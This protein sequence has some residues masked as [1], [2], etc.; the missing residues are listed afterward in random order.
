VNQGRSQTDNATNGRKGLVQYY[1]Q[2]ANHYDE[3]RFA[4]S[5]GRYL[6]AQERR[7]L[8]RWLSPFQGGTILDLACGTGRLLDLATHGIDA[9]ESMIHLARHKHPH[10]QLRCIEAG[11]ITELPTSFDAIF[12]LHFFMH[13]RPAQIADV[14]SITLSR[15]RPGGVLIFDVPS[16]QRRNLTGFRPGGWHAGTAL[17]CPDVRALAGHRWLFKAMHGVLFFPIHRFP[18]KIRPFVRPLDDLLGASALARISSY[19]L[20]CLERR[21]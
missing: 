8:R 19:V 20:Y 5:Y 21:T 10:K 17:N 18:E 16:S 12:C 2:L 15:L 3:S 14:I 4:T 6:D 13:L 7:V 9:S 1:D 11:R